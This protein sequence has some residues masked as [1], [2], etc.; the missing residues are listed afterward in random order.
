MNNVHQQLL[1]R[2]TFVEIDLEALSHNFEQVKK[3]LHGQKMLCV[4]KGNAYGHGIA[5]MAQ[6]FEN[7][8]ADYLAVAIPEEGVELRNAGITIPIL[9]LS[10]IADKQITVCIDYDLTISVPSDEKLMLIDSIARKSNARA[11]IHIKV[12]T[13]M[14]RIG[15]HHSR[16]KK[17][18]SVMKQCLHCDFEGLFSHFAQS[19]IDNEKNILQIE[20]FEKVIDE[21]N[22]AGFTFPLVHLA[23]SGG[24]LF[25]PKSHFTMV[26]AGM[27]LYGLFEGRELSKE[28]EL[29]P[30]MS[31][32]TEVVYF[33]F[34]EK[35]I[36]IGYG[37]KYVAKQ[38]TRIV[39]LPVGYADGY[40]R[41]MGPRGK[42]IINDTIYPIAGGICMDQMMIDIGLSGESYKGDEVILVGNSKNNSISF[43]DIAKWS[44]TSIY[45]LLSQISY[46]VPRI[47][48][49]KDYKK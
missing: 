4:V 37:H 19:D 7:L 46:R 43:F 40:Q 36:G 31:W 33:K 39:T 26:R 32:K 35:G 8:G 5:E 10:A 6:E 18:F 11:K 16:V 42:V 12:D 9:V 30:V 24:I 1:T 20:R 22:N 29:K 2:P 13:G 14:G 17:Y 41:A 28:I 45:E 27:I 49:K 21:F 15:V 44:N 23:N 47:Y 48:I 25:H 3:Q 38:D 34:I